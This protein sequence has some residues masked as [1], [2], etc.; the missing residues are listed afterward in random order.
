M[1]M[2]SPPRTYRVDDE[3]H[4]L[5]KIMAATRGLRV[6]DMLKYIV[7]NEYEHNEGAAKN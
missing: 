1:T 7:R 2:E 5:L 3:T 4:R 6:S